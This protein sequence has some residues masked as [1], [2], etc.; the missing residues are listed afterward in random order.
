MSQ[1]N[2]YKTYI[3]SDQPREKPRVTVEDVVVF[4]G[5][6]VFTWLAFIGFQTVL[7]RLDLISTR[8]TRAGGTQKPDLPEIWDELLF[9]PR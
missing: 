4:L 9:P 7:E 6:L 3:D 2:P 1:E 5:M 8:S